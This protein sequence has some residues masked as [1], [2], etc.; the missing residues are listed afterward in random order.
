MRVLTKEGE[1]MKKI[2]VI[3][4]PESI[5]EVS[6]SYSNLLGARYVGRVKAHCLPSPKKVNFD[7]FIDASIQ[8]CQ[9]TGYNQC[10][11]DIRNL[12]E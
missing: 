7:N 10:L 11:D 9:D 5:T 6:V 4:V 1:S 12:S 2:I 8:M 3:D